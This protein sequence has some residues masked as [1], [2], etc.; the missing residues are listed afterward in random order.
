MH[1]RAVLDRR[2]AEDIRIVDVTSDKEMAEEAVRRAKEQAK[3]H[4]EEQKARLGTIDIDEVEQPENIG[5]KDDKGNEILPI[6]SQQ[7]SRP[8]QRLSDGRLRTQESINVR[9]NPD[10]SETHR[11]KLGS[12]GTS[13]RYGVVEYTLDGSRITIDSIRTR[14]GYESIASDA[15]KELG[16]RYEGYDIIWSPETEFQKKIKQSLVDSNPRGA[17]K[18]L[19]WYESI[20]DTDAAIKLSQRIQDAFT[21]LNKDESTVAAQILQMAANAQGKTLNQWLTDNAASF[22][23]KELGAG[24]KGGIEL[25]RTESGIK[26]TITAAKGADFSTFAHE[27]FHL[28]RNTTNQSGNLA[29]ALR[30]ASAADEFKTYIKEHQS[31]IHMSPEEASMALESFSD[32]GTWTTEQEE[33]AAT[34]FESYLRDNATLSPKLKNLF[35]K[36]RDWFVRIYRSIRNT[37]KMDERIAKAFDSLLDADPEQR[38]ASK[39]SSTEGMLY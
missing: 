10:G 20:T 32:D 34:L 27:A 19:N 14:P 4:E 29:D 28:I 38:I 8:I 17:D 7:P 2:G 21:N 18:G 33:L 12:V 9:E 36:I 5:E 11:L 13:D 37:V 1:E 16:R 39:K 15:V 3:R 6:A 24:R 30:E 22:Q 25:S 23:K 31:V 35:E 26:A